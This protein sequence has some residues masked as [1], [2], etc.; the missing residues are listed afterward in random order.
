MNKRTLLNMLLGN[1]DPR[2]EEYQ[3]WLQLQGGGGVPNLEDYQTA[4]PE[5]GPGA[6]GG[7]PGDRPGREEAI[8]ENV[9]TT[10]QPGYEE[11]MGQYDLQRRLKEMRNKRFYASLANLFA[12]QKGVYGKGGSFGP[13]SRPFADYMPMRYWS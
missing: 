3:R 12:P 8:L 7:Y 5:A 1:R 13:A 11:A 9:I 6:Y 10:D 4:P 2:E